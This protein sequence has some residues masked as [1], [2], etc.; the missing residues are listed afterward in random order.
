MHLIRA[1]YPNQFSW[2]LPRS[3][4]LWARHLLLNAMESKEL[5]I[6][7][8][9]ATPIDIRALAQALQVF[10]TGEMCLDVCESGTAMRLLLAFLVARTDRPIHLRGQGRQHQRP[11]APLVS[12]LSGRGRLSTPVHLS[13]S[14]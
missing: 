3:K 11:I 9:E 10:K 7:Q 13:Q 2:K 5:N 12:A 8:E 6:L 1:N 14:A 4:S